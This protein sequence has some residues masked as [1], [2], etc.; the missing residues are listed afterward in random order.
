MTTEA[1]LLVL[2][3]TR[4]LS[5]PKSRESI[6]VVADQLRKLGGML[7]DIGKRKKVL[8]AVSGRRP[9]VAKITAGAFGDE[10]WVLH[11]LWQCAADHVWELHIYSSE[12]E[13]AVTQAANAARRL[14]S[15]SSKH[16]NFYLAC[17]L[18]YDA[19]SS[20]VYLKDKGAYDKVTQAVKL[21]RDAVSSTSSSEH[22]REM[23]R[24]MRSQSMS[25][26]YSSE[27]MKAIYDQTVANPSDPTWAMLCAEIGKNTHPKMLD[28]DSLEMALRLQTHAIKVL[29]SYQHARPIRI[30]HLLASAFQTRAWCL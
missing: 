9:D 3:L 25:K 26:H 15:I 1:L 5:R 29:R 19:I 2:T 23:M 24:A 18:H 4:T 14:I 6:V 17:H 11:D 13:A 27:D 7:R 28:N 8:E 10:E 21:F 12:R 20:D 16:T 30:Q 22:V